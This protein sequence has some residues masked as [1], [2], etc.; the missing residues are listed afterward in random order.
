VQW[1]DDW[2]LM[3][4]DGDGNGVG[5]P[6]AQYRK[7]DVGGTFPVA[8]PVTSD[9]FESNRL[10]LQWQWNANP[11]D[12][13]YSL[14]A[15]PSHLRL[16]SQPAPRTD[17]LLAPSLLLQKFPARAFS[18]ET[19]LEFAPAQ[20]GEE[21]GL[22]IMGRN[23]ASLSLYFTDNGFAVVFQASGAD[24]VTLPVNTHAV[25]LRVDVQDGGRCR[26]FYAAN[27]E[28]VEIGEPFQAVQGHWVG[29]RVG[30][31]CVAPVDNVPAGYADFRYF[32][33]HP[34]P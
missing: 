20:T 6:V 27:D 5:E 31:Y 21:A 15:R 10:G 9:A 33:F 12:D 2:P 14:G 29:A 19:A 7:P 30:L 26:F 3:G 11:R 28:F 22:I 34:A 25:R 24:A 1:Q 13:W 23:Y 8:V 4:I 17:L 32:E 18:V 16:L